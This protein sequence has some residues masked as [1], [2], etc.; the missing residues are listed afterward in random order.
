MLLYSMKIFLL[1]FV[2]SA[3]ILLLAQCKCING[4]VLTNSEAPFYKYDSSNYSIIFCGYKENESEEFIYASEFDVIDC[5]SENILLSF[6]AMQKCKINKDKK[7]LSII[8][9]KR[10][11]WGNS[12]EW[13]EAN[14]IKYKIKSI[15]GNRSLFDTLI[16]LDIPKPNE[17]ET[18][19]IFSTYDSAKNNK[20]KTTEELSYQLLM[21][22]LNGNDQ[23]KD[24]LL[25]LQE[26]LNLDGYLAEINA[27][28][29]KIY[30]NVINHK[31]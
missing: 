20:S 14:Y 18:I 2:F 12:Y 21:L 9:T 10:L 5:K 4:N 13:I 23:A 11:P 26:D 17:R 19:N 30:K 31:K 8:E 7:E 28:A 29:I 1:I 3:H 16:V 22:A 15:V 24:V 25:K 6:R 27:D